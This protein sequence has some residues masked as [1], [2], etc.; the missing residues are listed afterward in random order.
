MSNRKFG[1]Y[2]KFLRENFGH[3]VEYRAVTGHPNSDL[4]QIKDDL[5]NQDPF[6]VFG[7]TLLATAAFSDKTL[8]H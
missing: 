7:A 4:V 1:E 3:L 6:I 2:I 5:F 8:Y